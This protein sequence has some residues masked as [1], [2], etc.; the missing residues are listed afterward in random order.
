[1]TYGQFPVAHSIMVLIPS[2]RVEEIHDIIIIGKIIM[3]FDTIT[4]LVK[5]IVY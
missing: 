1:M 3:I 4:I 2:I 5:D